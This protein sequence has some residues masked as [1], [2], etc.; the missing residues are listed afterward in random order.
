MP[1]TYVYSVAVRRAD[2]V[3]VNTDGS[4]TTRRPFEEVEV[5]EFAVNDLADAIGIPARDLAVVD[6]AYTTLPAL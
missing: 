3:L 1:S 4:L 2:D 5:R 6:F